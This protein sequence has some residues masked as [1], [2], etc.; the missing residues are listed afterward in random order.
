MSEITNTHKTVA[1]YT[2]GCK[3]NFAETSSI[4]KQ[5][6]KNGYEIVPWGKPADVIIINTCTVTAQADKKSRKTIHK[7]TKLGKKVVVIGCSAQMHTEEYAQIPGVELVLG[8]KDKFRVFELL[9]NHQ[10]IAYHTDIQNLTEFNSA[11]S[12][13]GRTR[14]FLKIQDGCDYKCSYCIIPKARGKSRNAPIDNILENAKEIA[15]LGYKEI[16]LTG[17]NI[18]DFGR[19]TGETFYDLLVAL[20][21]KT[22]I[23]R[24]RISS[25][26]P[27]LLKDEI[28]QLV[29]NSDKFL[30]HF[31]IPLQSGSDEILKKMRRRY[32]T[33]LFRQRIERIKELI[34][35]AFIG[36]DVIVGFP[37]ETDELFEQ[38]YNFLE[39]LPFSF[40]HIFPYSDRPGTPASQMT[41]KISAQ[42]K[43]QREKKLKALSAQRHKNFYTQH[44]GK[45]YNVLFEARN[46]DGKILG[47]TDNY[48]RVELPYQ[49]DLIN[50]IRKVKLVKLDSQTNNV[51]GLL[52]D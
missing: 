45:T 37:G 32:N 47:F 22:E 33:K 41:E 2:L 1:G 17:V 20:D 44:L 52:I 14:S 9:E 36:I 26:E 23:P 38:T 12:S 49:T 11:Y 48:I 39:S 6:V 50:Q 4:L 51:I 29:A 34:P 18:G 25:V 42:Q 15:R 28:I 13:I 46:N 8:A 30:P 7:A 16:V 40:L 35:D 10:K 5:F 3:L 43:Q 27:E 31:H 24:I 19:S 21:K